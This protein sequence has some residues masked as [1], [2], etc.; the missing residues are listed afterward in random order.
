MRLRD[1]LFVKFNKEGSCMGKT[2]APMLFI[3][4]V[5]NAFKHGQKNVKP[6]GIE[7]NLK[8]RT[9]SITFDVVNHLDSNNE[10]NKDSTPGIG[11]ANTK[12]RLELLYPNRHEFTIRKDNGLYLSSLKISYL[13]Q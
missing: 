12:R 4:F 8:C 1:P 11:L 13:K 10:I 9:D 2:I 7:I 6:P 5:E 3:P